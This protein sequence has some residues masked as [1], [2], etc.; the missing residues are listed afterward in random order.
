MT[1]ETIPVPVPLTAIDTA[2]RERI[3][4]ALKERDEARHRVR[5]VEQ[6]RD[7]ANACW[8]VAQTT[9][10]RALAELSK[11]AGAK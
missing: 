1:H 5:V 4:E 3:A 9:W 11:V 8:R 7:E 10:T 6:E 2:A